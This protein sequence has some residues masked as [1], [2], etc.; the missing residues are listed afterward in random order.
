MLEKRGDRRR[1]GQLCPAGINCYYS[2]AIWY[3]RINQE[4]NKKTKL[5]WRNVL[6]VL[7]LVLSKCRDEGSGREER[8]EEHGI[9]CYC[10]DT[11]GA[12]TQPSQR[13]KGKSSSMI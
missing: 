12:K 5:K 3:V 1:T 7:E 9:A 13:G 2:R 4:R 6:G 11:V 8:M 10:A